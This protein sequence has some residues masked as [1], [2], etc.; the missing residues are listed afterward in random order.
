MTPEEISALEERIESNPKSRSFL[1]LAEAYIELGKTDQ[2][3]ALLSKGVEYYPYYLAARITLGQVQMEKG[4]I[5][6]AIANFEFVSRTIPDNLIAQKSLA[7]LYYENNE[8]EKAKEAVTVAASL[9]PDD[10]EIISLAN[11]INERK[12]PEPPLEESL[13][14]SYL[15]EPTSPPATMESAADEPAPEEPRLES[16]VPRQME[17]DFLPEQEETHFQTPQNDL[18]PENDMDMLSLLP[19]TETMGDLFMEQKRYPQA[20]H[21]YSEVLKTNPNNLLVAQKLA[22]AK[23]HFPLSALITENK[24]E[25]LI[26]EDI[27]D[28][29]PSEEPGSIPEPT[30]VVPEELKA[31]EIP[32]PSPEPLLPE[33]EKAP[34]PAPVF[35][36]R[37]IE[38]ST[39]PAASLHATNTVTE[40][41]E[42]LVNRIRQRLHRDVIDVIWASSDGLAITGSEK[43]DSVETDQ[44]FAGEGVEFLRQITELGSALGK[45][46]VQDGF[47]WMDEGILYFHDQ[48]DNGALFIWLHPNANVGRCRY[49]IGQEMGTLPGSHHKQ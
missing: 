19:K 39:E 40:D 8:L 26:E 9:S 36:D 2:A 44:I 6:E 1:Q 13:P 37:H 17:E 24:A 18:I 25:Y 49:I 21:I 3:E 27:Q 38:K 28:E 41:P 20:E 33:T 10:P 12:T 11:Q 32:P 42:D 35:V 15:Q 5:P 34:E 47:I 43:N 31:A 16:P 48:G 22:L 46:H 4:L 29:E 14:S 45:G 30:V 23:A 7:Q